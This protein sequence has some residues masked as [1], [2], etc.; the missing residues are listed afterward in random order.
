MGAWAFLALREGIG[1]T[2]Q[3]PSGTNHVRREDSCFNFINSEPLDGAHEVLKCLCFEH[4][5]SFSLPVGFVV[6]I[7]A[8]MLRYCLCS[9]G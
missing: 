7:P 3:E 1:P 6:V 2:A 9:T 8:K 4:R 5:S